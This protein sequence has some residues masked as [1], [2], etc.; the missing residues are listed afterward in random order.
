[1]VDTADFPQA[2]RLEQVGEV[3]IA[4]AKKDSWLLDYLVRG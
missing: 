3:A 4:I 2:D 1:M